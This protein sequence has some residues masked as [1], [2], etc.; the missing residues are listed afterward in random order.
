MT[1]LSASPACPRRLTALD[2]A[3]RYV[4][5]LMLHGHREAPNRPVR[6]VPRA[7]MRR[8]SRDHRRRSASSPS[9]ATRSRPSI[10]GRRIEVR[11]ASAGGDEMTPRRPRRTTSLAFVIGGPT[12]GSGGGPRAPRRHVATFGQVPYRRRADSDVASRGVPAHEDR[13]VHALSEWF[14]WMRPPRHKERRPGL[15]PRIA[16]PTGTTP[17]RARGGSTTP[18]SA[19]EHGLRVDVVAAALGLWDGRGTVR[20]TAG[21]CVDAAGHILRPSRTSSPAREIVILCSRYEGSN[22]VH[23]HLA[24]ADLYKSLRPRGRRRRR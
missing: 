5:D 6:E 21:W 1:R 17:L 15:G 11:A 3:D 18:R 2:D 24:V 10:S 9:P 20:T 19:A 12:G 8:W 7:P 13:R 23:E 16:S 4:R 14:D 22:R